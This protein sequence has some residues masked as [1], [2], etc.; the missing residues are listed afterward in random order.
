[1]KGHSLFTHIQQK[2]ARPFIEKDMNHLKLYIIKN[3]LTRYSLPLLL[4]KGK[5]QSS[6][7]DKLVKINHVFPLIRACMQ[8]IGQ[9]HFEVMSITDLRDGYHLLRLAWDTQKYCKIMLF[10][11]SPTYFYL[12]LNMGLGASPVI[13][14][15]FINKVFENIL[16]KDTR[17][18]WVILWFSQE[19]NIIL[20]T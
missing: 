20:K 19:N 9:T 7:N 11:G 17:S 2:G 3:W 8:V 10:Y 13:W 5:Q 6:L 12:R 16:N 18:L 15:Q 4:V 14:K 1:M